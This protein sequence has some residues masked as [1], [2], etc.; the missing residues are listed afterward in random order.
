MKTKLLLIF[1][2][3]AL[4]VFSVWAIIL[5]LGASETKDS[6]TAPVNQMFTDGMIVRHSTGYTISD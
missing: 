4:M 3:G 5:H 2:A 1:L 6:Y